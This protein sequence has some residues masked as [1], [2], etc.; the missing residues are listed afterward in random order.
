MINRVPSFFQ[1]QK[2][3]IGLILMVPVYSLESVRGILIPLF[4]YSSFIFVVFYFILIAPNGWE[5]LM[6]G[7]SPTYIVALLIRTRAKKIR[8]VHLFQV[9]CF[10]CGWMVR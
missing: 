7:A 6:Y 5:S 10:P 9:T 2:F 8:Q 1:E 4:F 3:L